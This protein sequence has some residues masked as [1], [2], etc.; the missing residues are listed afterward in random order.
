MLDGRVPS[1]ISQL[2]PAAGPGKSLGRAR[3][4][5]PCFHR[6][7]LTQLILPRC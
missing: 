5:N 4:E 1:V 7:Q 6:S 3:G 2:L